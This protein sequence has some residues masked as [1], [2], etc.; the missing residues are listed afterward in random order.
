MYLVTEE[1][2]EYDHGDINDTFSIQSVPKVLSLVSSVELVGT[3]LRKYRGVEPS[4]SPFNSLVQPKYE[5]V[6]SR[7]P[8]INAS[9]I[10]VCDILVSQLKA[11]YQDFI[12]FVR[13][14]FC[15]PSNDY[16]QETVQMDKE[17]DFYD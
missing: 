16:R 14:L 5:L 3:D 12:E 11:P 7:N 13:M 4:G 1:G 6:I 2:H 10:V 17:C 9:A 8:L 15:N